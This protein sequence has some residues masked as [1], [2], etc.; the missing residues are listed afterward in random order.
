MKFLEAD[1]VQISD[2]GS[3]LWVRSFRNAAKKKEREKEEKKRK[4]K[5]KK[6]RE[7]ISIWRA[8]KIC[9]MNSVVDKN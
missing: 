9:E 4:K 6:K 5:K 7:G 8:A 2:L 3:L 1:Q